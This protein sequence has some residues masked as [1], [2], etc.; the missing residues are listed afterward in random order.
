MGLGDLA[1]GEVD[2]EVG[3]GDCGEVR[4]RVVARLW[5]GGRIRSLRLVGWF[6]AMVCL[7]DSPGI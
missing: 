6:E 1:P 7:F 5:E 4:C 3:A 2:S